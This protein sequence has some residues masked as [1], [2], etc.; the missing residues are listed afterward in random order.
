MNAESLAVSA[1]INIGLAL[2]ILTLFSV[3]RKQPSNAPIYYARLLSQHHHISFDNRFFGFR[4]LIPSLGWI[5]RALHVTEDEILDTCGLDVLIFIRL[6]KFGVV[7]FLTHSALLTSIWNFSCMVKHSQWG[8]LVM[9]SHRDV[10]IPWMLSP[11]R[12]LG[13][14]L[15]GNIVGDVESMFFNS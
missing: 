12:T 11:Y 1:S 13:R 5:R 8:R 4:R 3:L 2:L 10:L 15:T 6:F 7:S 14:A 9:D